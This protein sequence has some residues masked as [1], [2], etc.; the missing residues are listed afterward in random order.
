MIIKDYIIRLFVKNFRRGFATNSSSSHSFVYFK[1]KAPGYDDDTISK[2][3]FDWEDFRITSIK[4]KL[5]Y[6]LVSQIGHGSYWDSDVTED[7][8]TYEYNQYHE[9]FPELTREDFRNALNGYVDHQSM[10]L[11]T[12]EEARDPRVVIYGGNDNDLFPSEYYLEDKEQGL[13]AEENNNDE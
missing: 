9:A 7:D 11:L 4:E 5:F 3:E 1:D 2:N 10:Y 12:P 13:I 6:V 8:V